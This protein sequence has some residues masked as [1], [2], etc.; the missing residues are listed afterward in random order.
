MNLFVGGSDR[1]PGQNPDQLF[2]LASAFGEVR[3][4]SALALQPRETVFDD[5]VFQR[6]EGDDR[7]P[8]A[9][10]ERSHGRLDESLELAELIVDRDP[11]CL[12]YASR[13]MDL[14]TSPPGHDPFDQP[15][16]LIGGSQRPLP[17]NGAGHCT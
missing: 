3:W 17:D 13:G 6:M 14:L 8:S 11:Q 4:T 2:A 15:A 12:K 16:K 10:S 1:A 9:R 7:H 5:P